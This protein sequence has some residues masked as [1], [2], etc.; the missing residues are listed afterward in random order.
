MA[1]NT[2][3]SF[4]VEREKVEAVTIFSWTPKSLRMVT[5][6]LILEDTS[7]LEGIL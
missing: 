2:I 4:Q 5:A 1:S 7:S 3:I 6:T